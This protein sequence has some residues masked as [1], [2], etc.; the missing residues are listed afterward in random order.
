MMFGLQISVR[1]C[2][3]KNKKQTKK[4]H[5]TNWAEEKVV[6]YGMF[7]LTPTLPTQVFDNLYMRFKNHLSS[8]SIDFCTFKY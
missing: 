4:K 5:K 7:G 3:K 2:Q 6:K 8:S 1:H